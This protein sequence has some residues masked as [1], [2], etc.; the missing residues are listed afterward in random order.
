M[1]GQRIRKKQAQRY[2]GRVNEPKRVE[3][4][5]SHFWIGLYGSLWIDSHT[6]WSTL[7]D[8]LRALK[9]QKR[10]FFGRGLNAIAS[11]QSAL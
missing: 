10:R 11:I 7:A 2:V 5:H 8:K 3:N 1:R 9:P 4:R 6:L